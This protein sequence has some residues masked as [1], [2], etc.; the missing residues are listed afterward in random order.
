MSTTSKTKSEAVAGNFF[1]DF[2]LGQVIRHATPR[3]LTEA[4]A[5]LNVG[6]YRSIRRTNL[7]APSACRARRSTISWCSTS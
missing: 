2:R 6:L 4:D 5:A 1:E 7:P 3:T